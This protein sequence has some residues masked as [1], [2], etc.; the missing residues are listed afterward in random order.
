MNSVTKIQSK[1]PY[2]KRHSTYNWKTVTKAHSASEAQ[3]MR[4]F[5]T[6]SD[7]D[8]LNFDDRWYIKI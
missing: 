3:T 7:I 6:V 1:N 5:K 2:L 4:F 8:K